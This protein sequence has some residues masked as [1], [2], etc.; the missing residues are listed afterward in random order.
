MHF[1]STIQFAKPPVIRSGTFKFFTYFSRDALFKRSVDLR[2]RLRLLLYLPR[3]SH[4]SYLLQ[5]A[6]F[7]S[8]LAQYCCWQTLNARL[9]I[10]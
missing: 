5:V 4:T 10:R 6:V 7:H 1:M 9:A 2:D 3:D 8:L